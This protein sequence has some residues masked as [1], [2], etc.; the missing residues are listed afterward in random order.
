MSHLELPVSGMTCASCAARVERTLNRLDGVTATV[1]YATERATVDFDDAAVAPEQLVDA[2]A[3]AGYGATLPGAPPPDAGEARGLRTR[4][5]IS[6]VLAVPVIALSMIGPLQFAGWELVA[7]CLATPVVLWG[8]WP[9]H[10]EAWRGLRHRT[11]TMGTLISIGTLAAWMWS[12]AA[13]VTDAEDL[14]LEV[15]SVVTVLV[16]A[17]RLLESRARGR[18]SSALEALLRTGARNA[19]VLEPDGTERRVPVEDLRAGDRFV[20]R[21]GERVAT[22]GVVEDGSSAV[23]ASILTGESRPVEKHPG[24]DVAGGSV[25]AGGRLVVRATR[26]GADTALAQ[27]ARLVAEAQSG[28]A[29]V[30]RLADRVSAVFVPAV[31]ALALATLVGWIVAGQGT[32]DAV[33]AAVAVLIIACPCALGLATPTALMVGTARGAQ[34]GLL[35][36][37]PEVLESTR[38]VDTVLL[39]KTGTVT[40]GRMSLVEVVAE[41]H[42][43]A[44][45]LVGALE[46]ASEHPVGRAIARAARAEFGL[47]PAVHDFAAT[48]GAGVAGEIAGRRVAAGRAAFLGAPV[49]PRLETARRAAE[50]R[51]ATA[52]LAAWDDEVRAVLVVADTVK[53]GSADAVAA[54]RELGLRPV[55][56][57][58]DNRATAEAVAAAVGIDEV[59]AEVLPAD[60][61]AAVSRLQAQGHVVAVAGDGV[62]DAPALAQADLGLAV[63]SG[64]DVAIEAS[65]LTMVSGDLRAVPDAIR[66]SRATLR[67]IRQNLAWAF[68]YNVAALPLAAAGV[69][70]PVIAAAAM[71]LSSVSVVGNALRLRRFRPGRRY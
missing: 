22:D 71:G 14:Y 34:L 49:P 40:T 65:D 61:A 53:P 12:V 58:G 70:S 4:L 17:G 64:A 39:D 45:R 43:E 56:L 27:I 15:A 6:T 50:Q 9:F 62:N 16:L 69:L 32:A 1:N 51:G 44:L 30:Q 54:L 35:I 47:L 23:D 3:S 52:V 21:P 2:V 46:D 67:T 8:A 18:A 41:D 38:G 57:T 25:N 29:R 66:L 36:K 11:A 55:L 59:V 37:G 60:K 19:A 33:S 42:G 10:R 13:V 31:V 28:K 5:R 24:D 48:P 7:L 26:V 68:A 63:G 20:V